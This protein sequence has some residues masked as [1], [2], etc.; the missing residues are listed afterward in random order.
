MGKIRLRHDNTGPSPD[1]Y[2]REVTVSEVENGDERVYYF[3]CNAWLTATS[4]G[5]G[6]L[7]REFTAAPTGQRRVKPV[8]LGVSDYA[9]VVPL[10][11]QKSRPPLISPS[12]KQSKER[13]LTKLGNNLL[14]EDCIDVPYFTQ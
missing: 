14:F 5:S 1:W 11:D 4:D 12:G 9:G 13:S 10:M 7:S 6:R 8:E 2:L 3:P